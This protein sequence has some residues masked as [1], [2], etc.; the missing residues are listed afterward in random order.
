MN[1]L[2]SL[3]K[4]K[5]K[6]SA[7]AFSKPTPVAKS[8]FSKASGDDLP[9]V[10]SPATSGGGFDWVNTGVNPEHLR[11]IFEADNHAIKAV[12]A[13]V[14]HVDD[15]GEQ[16]RRIAFVSSESGLEASAMALALG[17]KLSE[18]TMRVI[19]LDMALNAPT[20]SKLCGDKALGIS[21]ILGEKA[22]FADSILGDSQ[23]KLNILATGQSAL[24]LE[25]MLG[26]RR[27]PLMFEAVS[28]SYDRVLL[29]FGTLNSRFYADRITQLATFVVIVGLGN[30]KHQ[31]M[32]DL[33]SRYK[34]EGTI[35]IAVMMADATIDNKVRQAA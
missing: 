25:S 12:S 13:L 23:S 21:D 18:S 1:A 14:S 28:R 11:H 33:Y 22:S 4:K 8:F 26:H 19:A 20:L 9:H 3:F 7:V 5:E 30:A 29:D 27:M 32:I 34:S 31:A 2:L 35:E 24:T 10:D 6:Q 15:M 17:R 16:A